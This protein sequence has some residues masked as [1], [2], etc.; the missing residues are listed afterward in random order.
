M[1]Q[2]QEGKILKGKLKL[3]Y[4]AASFIERNSFHLVGQFILKS[5][6]NHMTDDL[7]LI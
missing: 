4:K 3:L 2:N 5:G 6:T 7:I 1:F